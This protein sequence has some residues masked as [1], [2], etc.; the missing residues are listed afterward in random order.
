MSTSLVPAPAFRVDSADLEHGARVLDALAP[1]GG[2]EEPTGVRIG[3]TPEDDGVLF[4]AD[5]ACGGRVWMACP[6][7]TTSVGGSMGLE[8]FREAV[9]AL[10]PWSCAVDVTTYPE[11]SMLA[12]T[13][14]LG[15]T[16]PQG[17]PTWRY[18][19]A[20]PKV[21][22]TMTR[23]AFAAA[24][25]T[26]LSVASDAS[27]AHVRVSVADGVAEFEAWG[28]GRHAHGGAP[29][30][31]R[32]ST[33]T[34]RIPAATLAG[35]LEVAGDHPVSLGQLETDEFSCWIECG[36]LTLVPVYVSAQL[37][38][39]AAR[40]K[41]PTEI[42]PR[43]A[44]RISTD[45]V[46]M[47]QT[48]RHI[49]QADADATVSLSSDRRGSVEVQRGPVPWSVLVLPASVDL[50]EVERIEIEWRADRLLWALEQVADKRV[51]LLIDDES[52]VTLVTASGS[53]PE[54]LT[55]SWFVVEYDRIS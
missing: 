24:A 38:V 31:E 14:P 47:I 54:D 48:V 20:S 15:Q 52:E 8:E 46:P 23:S 51:S 7:A 12:V 18:G 22:A 35:F 9:A 1:I 28:R 21:A 3:N 42:R 19:S 43:I 10:P 34:A 25:R 50:G 16:P 6:S 40:A 49:V 26:A 13:D 41:E 30:R 27:D 33:F 55:A 29:V 45:R 39:E 11:L 2:V 5:V 32:Q 53:T 4:V 17:L 37:W 44:R 36:P